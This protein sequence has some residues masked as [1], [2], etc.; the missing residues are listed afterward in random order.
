MPKERLSTPKPLTFV[1]RRILWQ[2]S[3]CTQNPFLLLFFSIFPPCFSSPSPRDAWG[4]VDV[5]KCNVTWKRPLDGV[6][7]A[8]TIQPLLP[9][10]RNSKWRSALHGKAEF[11]Y[12]GGPRL[13]C[14]VSACVATDC[15]ATGKNIPTSGLALAAFHKLCIVRCYS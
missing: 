14:G 3:I 8:N 15:L 13:A 6:H 11:L 7:R 10:S 9:P 12:Q 1:S 2:G 5:E 4:L